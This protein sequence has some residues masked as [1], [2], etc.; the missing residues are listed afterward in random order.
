MSPLIS[1]IVPVLDEAE[2]IGVLLADIA[3]LEIAHEVIVVDGGSQDATV[4]VARAAGATVLAAERGRGPQLRAGARA[5]N[6]PVLLFLHADVR[7]PLPTLREVERR[8]RQGVDAACAFRLRIDSPRPI[9]RVL[10]RG[11]NFRS[12]W[13]GLPY[14][15]QGLLVSRAA[16]DAVGGYPPVPLMEDVALARALRRGPGLQLLAPHVLVSPRRWLR[17]GP[18]RRTALN[19][20]LLARYLTGT[21]PDRLVRHYRPPGAGG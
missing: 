10:E 11:A 13:L 1:V 4:E 21:S 6:A 20:T 7:L 14:G 2:R 5:A 16:Y 3:V 19:L 17:D 12:R 8:A 15:D 18:I 9:F